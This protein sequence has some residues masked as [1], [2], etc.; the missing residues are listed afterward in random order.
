[1]SS[2]SLWI[3]TVVSVLGVLV[4]AFLA[5]GSVISIANMQISWSGALLVSAML[6]PVAFAISGIGAWWAYSLDAYQWVHY[7]MALP[8]VYLVIFVMAMLV[9]FKW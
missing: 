3:N 2:M 7:L 8:W 4:G 5:M 1:M 6:V 9:A